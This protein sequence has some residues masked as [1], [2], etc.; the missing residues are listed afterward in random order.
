VLAQVRVFGND[1][2]AGTLLREDLQRALEEQTV[3]SGGET[4][5]DAHGLP[6]A[7]EGNHLDGFCRIVSFL[8]VFPTEILG[9][10]KKGGLGLGSDKSELVGPWVDV[11]EG[12]GVYHDQL[13]DQALELGGKDRVDVALLVAFE[14]RRGSPG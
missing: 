3:G 2:M 8:P 1:N 9:E 12:G 10:L 5:D 11:L 14:G 4:D 6:V 7:G 13:I